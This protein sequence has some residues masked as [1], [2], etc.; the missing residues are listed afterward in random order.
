MDNEQEIRENRELFDS[1]DKLLSTT[2]Y[3]GLMII[4]GKDS[5]GFRLFNPNW[6]ALKFGDH[7]ITR[8]TESEEVKRTAIAARVK[9]REDSTADEF[10]HTMSMLNIILRTMSNS[11]QVI[12]SIFDEIERFTKEYIDKNPINKDETPHCSHCAAI[13][14]SNQVH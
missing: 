4:A 9:I 2:K 1:I 8:E 3:G 14:G 6:S 5:G 11:H 10:I 12:A 7:Q 13:S